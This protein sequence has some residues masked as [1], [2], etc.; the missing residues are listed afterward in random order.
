MPEQW[1][2]VIV[3]A[4]IGAWIVWRLWAV[5]L[6]SVFGH[7]PEQAFHAMVTAHA[8]GEAL[9]ARLPPIPAQERVEAARRLAREAGYPLRFKLRPLR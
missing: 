6:E 2:T 1:K 9:I 4:S 7:S 5:R 3:L 8:E